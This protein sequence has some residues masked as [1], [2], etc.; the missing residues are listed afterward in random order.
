MYNLDQ[1]LGKRVLEENTRG[2]ES[3]GQGLLNLATYWNHLGIKKFPDST[4][5]LEVLIQ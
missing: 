4:A 5:F 1:N 2:K 3:L